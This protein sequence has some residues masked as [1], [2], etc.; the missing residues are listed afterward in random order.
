MLRNIS[1]IGTKT[2]ENLREGGEGGEESQKL[3][4]T[5]KFWLHFFLNLKP[6]EKQGN[7]CHEILPK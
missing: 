5:K 6:L 4:K 2:A 1:K 7:E 3:P